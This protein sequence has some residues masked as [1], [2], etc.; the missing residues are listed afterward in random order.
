MKWRWAWRDF[1]YRFTVGARNAQDYYEGLA[2]GD[3]YAI[4]K[5]LRKIDK[6]ALALY[7]A[8]AKAPESYKTV[9]CP[10]QNYDRQWDE[11]VDAGGWPLN[12]AGCLDHD[13][14]RRQED[15]GVARAWDFVSGLRDDTP[16]TADL[17]R[18]VHREL[19]GEIYPF[20]GE[21]RTVALAKGSGFWPLPPNGIEPHMARIDEQLLSKTPYYEGDK[22]RL[23]RFVAEVLNEVL[24]IH[25]FREGN[26]RTA[27]V[28]GSLIF[29]Q[30]D[31]PPITEWQ[32]DEDE[33]PYIQACEAGRVK[34]DH[35][36]LAAVLRRWLDAALE[37]GGT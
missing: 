1:G 32:R 26:G 12:Y 9:G 34:A 8:E 23:C 14:V 30:N 19:M 28:V 13:E 20:A 24:A 15:V 11:I 27:R 36:P 35:G 17:I 2:D 16:L 25:P 33:K 4:A 6:E 31:L 37:R 21:W 7:Y 10:W 29:L 3:Y 22:D 18:E 5:K